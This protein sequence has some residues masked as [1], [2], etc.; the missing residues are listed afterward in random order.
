VINQTYDN[1]EI[2]I[3]DDGSTDNTQDVVKS[4]NDERIKYHRH[5]S[6]KNAS[7]ARNTGINHA[8]GEYIAFLDSDD[9]WKPS[10]LE[11][12]LKTLKNKD[13]S[14]LGVYCGTD[15]QYT[16]ILKP[17]RKRIHQKDNLI[18][19]NREIIKKILQIELLPFTSTLVVKTEAVSE[20]SGCDE[21]FERHQDY[22]FLIRLLQKGKLACVPKPLVNI[23][24]SENPDPEV[25]HRAKQLFFDKFSDIIEDLE[26]DG[27]DIRSKHHLQL[28]RLYFSTGKFNKGKKQ[29]Q[30]CD[31]ID[32]QK[33]FLLIWSVCTGISNRF[34]F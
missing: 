22:E 18:E 2:I 23:Y 24:E 30:L 3:V 25:T 12:Q 20:L 13:G 32:L 28:A 11:L 8:S 19:G 26:K 33:S 27:Y 31:S 10:K 9:E 21:N 29:I 14:W 1:F 16:G 4:Y 17:I 5:D 6:N 15:I 7:A 34:N